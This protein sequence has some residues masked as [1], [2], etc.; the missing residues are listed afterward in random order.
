MFTIGYRKY[1]PRVLPAEVGCLYV[2]YLQQV[3]P[4]RLFL[5]SQL[6]TPKLLDSPEDSEQEPA[7][8]DDERIENEEP[9]ESPKVYCPYFV[10]T[11][12]RI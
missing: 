6:D 3:L 8:E 1:V 2:L 5:L 4:L 7:G 11:D 12:N 9:K 10:S